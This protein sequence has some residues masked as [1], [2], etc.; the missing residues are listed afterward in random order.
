MFRTGLCSITHRDLSVDQ[1][2]ELALTC[3]LEG[4]E[5]GGDVH[6]PHGE[7]ELAE[8]VL[9]RTLAAGLLCPSYGSYYKIGHSE[10]DGLKFD[11]VLDTAEALG[12]PLIRVWAGARNSEDAPPDYVEHI[13]AE[14]Y[15]LA[16]RAVARGIMLAFEFHNGSLTNTPAGCR[17]L[18]EA[19]GCE[20]VG[21]YW[22]PVA[23]ACEADNL[24]SLLTV[25]PWLRHLHVFHW[26]KTSTPEGKQTIERHP[27]A[28]GVT[29][30]RRYLEAL[31]GSEREYWTY[32]EFSRNNDPEQT[33][34]DA[35]ILK[36]L[37]GSE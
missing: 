12:V 10:E 6:V 5:W 34:Q 14:T 22:Q 30:W 32:L 11:A 9:D 16:E 29:A 20:A 27:L 3:G 13:A 17:A 4:I 21:T 28:D 8:T 23:G 25:K 31:D 37:T 35:A 2:I 36:Q 15:R 7:I 24:A 18:M 26:S 33:V 19:I 1:I